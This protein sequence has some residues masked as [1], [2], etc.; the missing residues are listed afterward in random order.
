MLFFDNEL[1]D[2][3][4]LFLFLLKF[5][6]GKLKVILK[7]VVCGFFFDVIFVMLKCGFL[8]FFSYWLRG[9]FVLWVVECFFGLESEFGLIFE[10]L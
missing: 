8:N 10:F 4:L 5:E 6:G 2:W 7:V 9:D 1:V 3:V